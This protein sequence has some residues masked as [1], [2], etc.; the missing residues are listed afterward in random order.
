MLAASSDPLIS[1]LR[2]VRT[3]KDMKALYSPEMLSLL[4]ITPDQ[5][6]SFQEIYM[7]L[8]INF[9]FKFL[10]FLI[11]CCCSFFTFFIQM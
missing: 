2:H 10:L 9:I 11:L 8:Y 4:H 3:Q 5:D 6:D 1:S 7:Y